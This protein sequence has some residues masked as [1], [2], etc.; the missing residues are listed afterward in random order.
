MP[1][2]RK[3]ADPPL[4]PASDSQIGKKVKV[5]D[6]ASAKGPSMMGASSVKVAV[7][8]KS[9]KSGDKADRPRHAGFELKLTLRRVTDSTSCYRFYQSGSSTTPVPPIQ[10][11]LG[12]LFD[13]YRGRMSPAAESIMTDDL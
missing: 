3:A 9:G 12:K 7:R 2:K 5:A 11:S 13:Q 4:S 8:A 6:S 10:Q 1:K